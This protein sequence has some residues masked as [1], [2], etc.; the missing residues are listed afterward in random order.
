MCEPT[1]HTLLTRVQC[2]ES[3]SPL[4]S[5]PVHILSL[6]SHSVG[7]AV[8]EVGQREGQVTCCCHGS[9]RPIGQCDI[10]CEVR[11]VLSAVHCWVPRRVT[12]PSI[13]FWCRPSQL[14]SERTHIRC[15]YSTRCT[16][17]TWVSVSVGGG[18]VRVQDEG[19]SGMEMM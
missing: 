3:S 6:H 12:D 17:G 16:G 18:G 7:C 9:D 10:V 8:L 4:W 11:P 19:K 15:S 13:I 1:T 14:S 5:P 2:G